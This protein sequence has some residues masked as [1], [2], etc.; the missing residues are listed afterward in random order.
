MYSIPSSFIIYS[1]FFLFGLSKYEKLI[2]NKKE[3]PFVLS[4]S[5]NNDPDIKVWNIVFGNG[6]LKSGETIDDGYLDLEQAGI[7]IPGQTNDLNQSIDPLLGDEYA[8]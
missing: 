4:F 8:T 6:V 5:L 7:I 3:S 2:V 1:K